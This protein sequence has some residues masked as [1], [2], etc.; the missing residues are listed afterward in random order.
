M[1]I[2]TKKKRQGQGVESAGKRME[3]GGELLGNTEWSEKVNLEQT[4]AESGERKGKGIPNR[5]NCQCKGSEARA[6]AVR[7][8]PFPT[9]R[10]SSAMPASAEGSAVFWDKA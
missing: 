3:S 9:Q 2:I 6:G 5:G 4:P 10:L 8:T 7:K 1:V